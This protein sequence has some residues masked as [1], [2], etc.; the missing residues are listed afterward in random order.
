MDTLPELIT[1]T[2]A[3]RIVREATCNER[4]QYRLSP[5]C[6]LQGAFVT[7][8]PYPTLTPTTTYTPSPTV[9]LTRITATPTATVTPTQTPS[10]TATPTITLTPTLTPTSVQII[11]FGELVSRVAALNLSFTP[12][13]PREV[14]PELLLV[15]V[16]EF[17]STGDDL[18]PEGSGFTFGFSTDPDFSLDNPQHFIAIVEMPSP[19]A[20]VQEWAAAADMTPLIAFDEIQG[21]E[22]AVMVVGREDGLRVFIQNGVFVFIITQGLDFELARRVIEAM[23]EG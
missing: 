4:I 14:P 8:T 2:A 23:L 20:T 13:L 5:G 9:D 16:K 22:N 7:R 19:F 21:V 1:W 18:I 10:P 3:N 17:E 6:D 15:R 11:P 12:I